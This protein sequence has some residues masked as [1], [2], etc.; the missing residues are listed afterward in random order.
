MIVSFSELLAERRSRGAAAGAFTCY[1]L[2]TAVGV[3]RAAS[4]GASGRDPPRQR[5]VV[6]R[7][8]RGSP[9]GGAPGRRGTSSGTRLRPARP[10]RRPRADR[11]G[12]RAWSGRRHGGWVATAS[13]GE[14]RARPARSRDRTP[15][16]RA[17]RSRARAR[18]G[19][20]GRGDGRGDRG[21]YRSGR[22]GVVHRA[23]GRCLP[24]RFDRQ[25]PRYV[26]AATGSRLGPAR[27]DPAIA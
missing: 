6:P 25:R 20:R 8:R 3:V 23:H 15:S 26:P 13:P 17:G 16:G 24:R 9:A 1:N 21:A 2:E 5:A 18:V 4:E 22:G 12:V 11:G 19:R 27:G 10:R 7:R 14:R